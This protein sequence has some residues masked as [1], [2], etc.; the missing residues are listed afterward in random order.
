MAANEAAI[1]MRKAAKV[2]E[3]QEVEAIVAYQAAKVGNHDDLRGP[4]QSRVK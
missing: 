3:A 2:R 1:E 4:T